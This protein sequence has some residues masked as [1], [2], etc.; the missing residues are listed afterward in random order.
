MI[1]SWMRKKNNLKVAGK[2]HGPME[3][4]KKYG[5]K[6]CRGK[7]DLRFAEK[8]HDPKMARKKHGPMVAGKIMILSWLKKNTLSR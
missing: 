4:R 5:P 2:K 8:N 3:A 6:V 1:L 7:N